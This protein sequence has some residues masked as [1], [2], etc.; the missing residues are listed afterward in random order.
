MRGGTGG[1]GRR[2]TLAAEP[3]EEVRELSAA[4]VEQLLGRQH[5]WA[6]RHIVELGG[7]RD[8][9]AYRFPLHGVRAYQERRAQEFAAQRGVA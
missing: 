5:G 9:R 2:V 8:A 1:S 7:Y 3:L 4:E 6:R